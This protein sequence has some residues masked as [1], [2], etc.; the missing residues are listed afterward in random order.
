MIPEWITRIL[1]GMGVE[2]AVIWTLSTLLLASLSANAAQWRHSMKVYGYRLSERDTLNKALTEASSVLSEM[3]KVTEERNEI[4]NE[5][6]DLLGKQSHAFEI[7]RITITSQ[8]DTVKTNHTTS[9]DTARTVAQTITAMS[10][11]IRTLNNMVME[12]RI[13]VTDQ[14]NSI[15]SM[16]ESSRQSI[17]AEIGKANAS[18]IVE[19]RHLMGESTIIQ[20]RKM[21]SS[22]KP[23]RPS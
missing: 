21:T 19:M 5:H 8:F 1:Q 9:T 22:S 2:G 20:R 17:L 12:S 15:K 10:E 7:L 16:I 14:M 13:V 18:N 23:K 6:A 4:S 11:S 3:L